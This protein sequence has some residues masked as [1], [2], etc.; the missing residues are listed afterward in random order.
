MDAAEALARVPYP[1]RGVLVGRHG[2]GGL[3]LAYVLTGRSPASRERV[4]A[5]DGE[6]L[7]V[8]PASQAGPDPLRHYQAVRRA[9]GFLVAG[10]GDHVEQLATLV[11]DGIAPNEALWRLRPEPD[12]LRTARLAAVVDAT[13]GE[14]LVGAARALP[15]PGGFDHVVLRVGEIPQG[16]GCLVVTYGGAPEAPSVDG[17]PTWVEVGRS[18]GEDLAAMWSALDARFRVALAG[19]SLAPGAPWAIVGGGTG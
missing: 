18:L 1:G 7:L 17:R 4:L 13:A 9:S 15:A 14:I 8:R 10:N 16:W 2:G 3:S 11:E 5:A 6:G 12:E 19:R